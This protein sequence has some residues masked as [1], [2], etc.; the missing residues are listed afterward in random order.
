MKKTKFKN[1]YL[2][3]GLGFPLLLEKAEF[4][5]IAGKWMLKV[6]VEKLSELVI[7]ALPVKNSG[8]TGS[9]IRFARTY[10]D[11]SKREFAKE[12]NVS[13]TTVNKWE[14]SGQDK[15]K[16]DSSLE[17]FLRAYIKLKLNQEKDF[18]IFYK[19]LIEGA[20]HF[21]DVSKSAPL[22]IAV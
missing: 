21:S 14:E 15:A 6:D 12:L 13:H 17:V 3:N 5:L 10:F 7:K 19:H 4:S 22:S 9:E 8:L 18:A 20:R 16:I 1:N 2:Y 11:L